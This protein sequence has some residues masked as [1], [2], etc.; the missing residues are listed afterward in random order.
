MSLQN[1]RD[2]DSDWGEIDLLGVSE[3][4]LP[5]IV[6]L[7]A[8]GSD[9]SPAQ[10]LVQGTAYAVA[11]QK[12][13]PKCLRVEWTKSVGV[14]QGELPEELSTYTI[15]GADPKAYWEKW[16]GTSPEAA[17]VQRKA[18]AAIA[19][20]RKWLARTGFRSVFVRLDY[21]GE[22]PIGI[23]LVEHHLPAK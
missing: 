18:W 6:E 3:D 7:K 12:A 17:T 13:W 15:V 9:E 8:P 5:V 14:E 1:H 22:G 16:T 4:K 19:D 23:T 11:L 10:M 2:T 20:L 21:Q